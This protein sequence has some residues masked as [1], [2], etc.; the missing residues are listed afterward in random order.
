[1]NPLC[2]IAPVSIDRDGSDNPVV[3][4]AQL[5]LESKNVGLGLNQASLDFSESSNCEIEESDVFRESSSSKSVGGIL[6]KWVN[7]GKGWRPRWFVLSQDG[8]LSY[9][10]I[11]GPDKICLVG[12]LRGGKGGVKLIGDD[13]FSYINRKA[14][15]TYRFGGNKQWKPFGEIHLKVSHLLVFFICVATLLLC[16]KWFLLFGFMYLRFSCCSGIRVTL[17]C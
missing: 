10:K 13:S 14:T 4:K 8:V 16:A 7:Y 5:G 9:Y 3:V 17:S 12:S 2:C 11:H 15:Q 6:Y 1:M